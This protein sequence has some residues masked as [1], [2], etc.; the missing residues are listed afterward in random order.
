MKNNYLPKKGDIYK[1]EIG[2]ITHDY[3]LILK[4]YD[5]RLINEFASFCLIFRPKINDID[6]TIGFFTLE[7][8]YTKLC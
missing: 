3:I 6:D 7:K 1:H 2:G 5:R 8:F 4:V